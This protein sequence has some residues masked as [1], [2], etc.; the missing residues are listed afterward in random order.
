MLGI[1]SLFQI[2]KKISRMTGNGIGIGRGCEC[3]LL[4][5]GHWNCAIVIENLM[6]IRHKT[7][8]QRSHDEGYP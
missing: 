6:K 5:P 7:L 1:L 4:L 3:I 2:V 8:A